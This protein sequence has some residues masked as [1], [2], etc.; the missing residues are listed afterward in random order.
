M[1]WKDHLGVGVE[2]GMDEL[3]IH[4][5]LGRHELGVGR[6]DCSDQ[7][8]K[9]SDCLRIGRSFAACGQSGIYRDFRVSLLALA[10]VFWRLRWLGRGGRL[11]AR[12]T[13]GVGSRSILR[14]RFL[15]FRFFSSGSSIVRRTRSIPRVFR[16]PCALL[17]LDLY[18]TT[19]VVQRDVRI[20]DCLLY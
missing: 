14:R 15:S 4:W 12:C 19:W 9:E 18:S 5:D 11:S 7:S 10:Q 17:L 6:V 8:L 13:L 16:A 20:V 3:L 1:A 2:R